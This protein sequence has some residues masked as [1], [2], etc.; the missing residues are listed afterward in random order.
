M[1]QLLQGMREHPGV[2]ETPESY[3]TAVPWTYPIE[4]LD[5]LLRFGL[6]PTPETPPRFVRE[7]LSGLYR[8]EI[9]VLRERLLAKEF[10]KKDYIGHVITLRKKYWP[11]A[12][13]PEQWEK[14]CSQEQST[15]KQ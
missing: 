10:P 7:Q 15:M 3:M 6:A 8:Y 13:T 11:L 12:L 9:R 1:E 4:L 2:P 5:A 14:I